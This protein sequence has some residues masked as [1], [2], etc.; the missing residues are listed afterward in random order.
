MKIGKHNGSCYITKL[1]TVIVLAVLFPNTVTGIWEFSRPTNNPL[2]AAV[3]GLVLGAAGVLALNYAKGRRGRRDI[4]ESNKWHLEREAYEYITTIDPADCSRRLICD[5]A[6]GEKEFEEFKSILYMLPKE[7][8][9]IPIQLRKLSNQ[10]LTA[11]KF[12]ETFTSIETC[13][14]TF[15]CPLSGFQYKKILNS[16]NAYMNN[17]LV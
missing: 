13:E 10:L 15:K 5:A 3:G 17:N 7:G 6:T 14:R 4:T 11:K 1:V 9:E 12:G 2:Q 16:N 8:D